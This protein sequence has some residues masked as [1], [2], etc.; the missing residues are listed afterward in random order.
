MNDLTRQ[1]DN[2]MKRR[3]FFAKSLHSCLAAA[4]FFFVL[5][6]A[7]CQPD[8]YTE[9]QSERINQTAAIETET[10]P[11]YV[12]DTSLEDCL[13]CGE[14]KGTLLPLYR[15]Q[16]NLGIINLNSFDLAPVTIN[17]YNDF[18]KLIEEAEKGSS[19][20]ITSTG[21]DGFFF[22]VTADTNRGYA[23]GQLSFS[24]DEALD[25]KKTA[26]HLCSDCLNRMMD[27]CWSDV[28][29]CMGVIDFSTGEIRLFEEK[30]TAFTFG[31]YYISCDSRD[32]DEDDSRDIDLLIFYCPE[33]YQD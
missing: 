22:S 20:H 12:S 9:N 17:R 6:T 13:V 23:H 5:L 7:G 25:M 26:S 32:T 8:S 30:I 16:E 29:F 10:P 15:G 31:D 33:R 27:R 28:P 14:G 18:G 2:L 21:E 11:Q 24:K 1:E 4:A 3:G 19:T